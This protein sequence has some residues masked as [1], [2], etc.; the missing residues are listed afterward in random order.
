M[1]DREIEKLLR[2]TITGEKRESVCKKLDRLLIEEIDKLKMN[3]KGGRYDIAL[4]NLN[5]IR[6]N[7]EFDRVICKI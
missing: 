1:Q 2:E 7:L 4:D 3:A 5:L 6:K